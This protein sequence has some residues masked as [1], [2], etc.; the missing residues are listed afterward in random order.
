MI[1]NIS[2]VV[3]NNLCTGCGTCVALCPKKAIELYLDTTKGLFIP[4]INELKCN[5]C[6]IC[7]K[8]CP[9]HEINFKDLN[10]N[11]FKKE[12]NNIFTGN[13]LNNYLGFSNNHQIRYNASSGGIITQILIYALE[14]G[15]ING[16][17]VT[18]MN[19]DNPLVPEPFIATTKDEIIEASTSKY[20]PVP[21]NIAL[22]MIL[23]SEMDKFAVVGLPCHIQG[24][25][26]AEKENRDLQNKIVL[27]IGMFCGG[28]NSFL[29][30][31]FLLR[32]LKINKNEIANLNYRGKGWP[33]KMFLRFHDKSKKSIPYPNYWWGFDS[34]FCPYRCS[35]CSDW[36][37][38]LSD[39]SVGD[40]WI[41]KIV[42]NDKIGTSIIIIR[43]SFTN[44]LLKQMMI[45]GYINLNEITIKD[46]I[47]SQKGIFKKKKDLRAR[48]RLMELIRKKTPKNDQLLLNIT[49]K[50]YLKATI[51]YLP[52][53]LFSNRT[54]WGI[55]EVYLLSLRHLKSIKSK[56]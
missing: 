53:Y 19:N 41:P 6:N 39:I 51:F 14:K 20:C 36:T 31:E 43:N 24:I 30:T 23:N 12:S 21:A 48:I 56:L 17:L 18:R 13:Y 50:D 1:K 15:V 26:K 46:I 34:F 11:I 22:E 28:L 52:I 55:L 8:I 27:H 37:S 10:L 3:K 42:K 25:R 40:A 29:G 35:L 54:L 4:K 7:Y 44:N 33:G 16:A 38:E 47:S 32:Q 45:K 2:I 5:N 9:G 49:F